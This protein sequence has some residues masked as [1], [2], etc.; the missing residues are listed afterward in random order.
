MRENELEEKEGKRGKKREFEKRKREKLRQP[1]Q[2]TNQ[3]DKDA[4]TFE[5]RGR[6]G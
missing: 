1:A 3:K 5:N 6:Q 4:R 2:E